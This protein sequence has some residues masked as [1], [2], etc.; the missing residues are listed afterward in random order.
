MINSAVLSILVGF[1][2][3]FSTTHACVHGCMWLNSIVRNC[4]WLISPFHHNMPFLRK[5]H[6]AQ[7]WVIISEIHLNE[8]GNERGNHQW[9][10]MGCY[11][12][13]LNL[14]P[15]TLT[16]FQV[17]PPPCL[18]PFCQGSL[19][20]TSQPTTV[21][22]WHPQQYQRETWPS[23]SKPSMS[24]VSLNAA[25]VADRVDI[26]HLSSLLSVHSFLSL[27]P[28]RW[29]S[30]QPFNSKMTFSC[31]NLRLFTFVH[32]YTPTVLFCFAWNYS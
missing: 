31:H 24:T 15:L 21:C 22:T 27:Q 23:M 17:P 3:S 16:N 4:L 11:D 32:I 9:M 18:V 13:T 6:T 12:F 8:R 2:W 5:I 1:R 30:R 26:C 20:T 10:N 19:G 28:S 25:G 7:E 14:V 29:S